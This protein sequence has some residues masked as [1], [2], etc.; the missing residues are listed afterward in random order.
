MTETVRPPN[1]AM[2]VYAAPQT[3][4]KIGR[5]RRV[6]LRITGEG[7]PTV[8][9]AAGWGGWMLSWS[10]VQRRLEATTRVVAY[11]RPGLGFS[12]PGPSPRAA[13]ATVADLRA[14]LQA[15]GIAPPYVLVGHSLGSF[16]ARL[17]AFLHPDEVVGLVLVDPS[18]ERQ[19]RRFAE[20]SPHAG[21]MSAR[22]LAHLRF[23]EA[24][25]RAGTLTPGSPDYDVCVGKPEP[26]LTDAV[27][28]VIARMRSRA[29]YWRSI[30]S[31][32]TSMVGRSAD[33]LEAAK[34][35]LDIPLIVLSAGAFEPG[36]GLSAEEG[37]AMKALWRRMHHE[38]AA[39]SSR[40]ELRVVEGAGHNI[41]TD[42]PQAVADAIA[43][44]VALAR[45]PATSA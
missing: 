20:I 36:P 10:G 28:A 9:L 18:S 34:R 7:G 42:K 27:N 25:A 6:N 22:Q 5:G 33:E 32:L 12:D 17:F 40:G 30:R 41:P 29:S 19:G 21:L 11:D 8:L 13:S 24:C 4:A 26:R 23:C 15:A 38:L 45:A 39:I 2:N 31:E 37:A 3:L 43:E 35:P 14:A 16:E 1:P 44:V